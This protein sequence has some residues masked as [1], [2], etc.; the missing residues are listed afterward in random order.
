LDPHRRHI[1]IWNWKAGVLSAVYRAPVFFF[2]S[3]RA[4]WR[5]ALTAMLTETAFRVVTSGFY[6]AVTEAL[7]KL[8]PA[9]LAILIVLLLAP[10][11]VQVLEFGVHLFSG[12]PNLHTG[13]FV[14]TAMTAVA[15][16]FNWFSMRQGALLTGRNA[17][18]FWSDLKRFP[19]LIF[20]FVMAIPNAVAERLARK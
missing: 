20:A 9:W 2:T 11:V 10:A 4:G 6:G 3:L 13:V 7:R 19:F 15:S 14:S 5:L 18:S 8:E 16:L 1:H 17:P 12:T